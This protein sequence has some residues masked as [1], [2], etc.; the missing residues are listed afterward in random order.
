LGYCKQVRISLP[1]LK[2]VAGTEKYWKKSYLDNLED[3]VI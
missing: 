2:L 3:K 1:I